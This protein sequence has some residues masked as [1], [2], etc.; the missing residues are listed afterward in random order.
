MWNSLR[1]AVRRLLPK[2][3]GDIVFAMTLVFVCIMCAAG[4]QTALKSGMGQ[5]GEIGSLR[6][7]L[8]LG[9]LV[10][11]FTN[12]RV[13]AGMS[14]YVISMV[15]WLGALSN[16]KLSFMYP[17]LSLSYVLTAISA[18]LFLGE[19]LTLINWVGISL[20]VGGCLLIIR[21]G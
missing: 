11:I 12:H 17:L 20:V 2:G 1:D 9:T 13:L 19:S 16:L 18:F 3:K 14:L 15:L 6:Q 10:R 4:G 7:L 5:V 21:A 8:N